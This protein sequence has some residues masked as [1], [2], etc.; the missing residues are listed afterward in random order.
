MPQ[1]KQEHETV[2]TQLASPFFDLD[3][4]LRTHPKL[5]FEL[6]QSFYFEAAHSLE[7]ALEVGGE[8][9]EASRRIHGHT[10]VAHVTLS[11]QPDSGTG[12]SVD[13]GIVR[14]HIGR[15]RDMLDHRFLDA[16]PGLGPATLENLCLFIWRALATEL[17]GVSQ[18]RVSREASGDSCVLHI[19]GE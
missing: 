15:V 3:K 9:I 8:Q 17:E 10:Y 14:E 1:L 12:M 2:S 13:L 11:A 19:S 6:S 16:V 5:R 18:V 7:R 4:Y